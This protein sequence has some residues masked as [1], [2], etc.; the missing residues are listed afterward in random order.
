MKSVGFWRC[1]NLP[2]EWRNEQL[3]PLPTFEGLS[4]IGFRDEGYN[5]FEFSARW[6][7]FLIC[8]QTPSHLAEFLAEKQDWFHTV[9]KLD[10]YKLPNYDTTNK[11]HVPS[12]QLNDRL[13]NDL[14][15]AGLRV[16]HSSPQ[17]KR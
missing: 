4:L 8:L 7:E 13:D 15:L 17:T 2:L 5:C 6:K 9:P 1:K 14:P 12:R 16:D 11:R 3:V 10:A